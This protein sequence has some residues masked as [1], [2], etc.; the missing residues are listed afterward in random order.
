MITKAEIK[1]YEEYIDSYDVNWNDYTHPI[2]N[3][4]GKE[5][6]PKLVD[7]INKSIK[8]AKKDFERMCLEENEKVEI[9]MRIDDI[10]KTAG[11]L[12]NLIISNMP[13]LENGGQARSAVDIILTS[14]A[15]LANLNIA[16]PDDS[17]NEKLAQI[18]DDI[19]YLEA[20]IEYF[21]LDNILDRLLYIM[22]QIDYKKR[23]KPFRKAFS[24]LKEVENARMRLNRNGGCYCKYL[25]EEKMEMSKA[26]K[27]LD[28]AYALVSP[29]L[30]KMKKRYD[31]EGADVFKDSPFVAINTIPAIPKI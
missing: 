12:N 26:I 15:F 21:T 5:F 25:L 9:N 28:D 30:R 3:E 7:S 13:I 2:G 16:K 18:A 8:S 17:V 22:S 6:L 20:V 23:I 11:E 31:V 10:R 19:K 24:V 1:Q 14:S 4:F 29:G 27:T